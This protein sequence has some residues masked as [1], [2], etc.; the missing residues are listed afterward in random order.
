[1]PERGV[2]LDAACVRTTPMTS[3]RAEPAGQRG[4]EHEHER[5]L[6]AGEQ[7]GER[8]AGQRGVRDRVAEQALPAQHR[9]GAERAARDARA[10]PTPSAHGAQRVV[11]RR[12]S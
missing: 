5:R 8:D 12:D 4:A 7:E 1:M 10:P 11:A 9:E 3:E 2:V 6:A